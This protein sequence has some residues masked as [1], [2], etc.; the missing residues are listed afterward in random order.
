MTTPLNA[1]EKSTMV[2]VYTQNSLLR[3]EVVTKENVRVS[4]W[5]RTDGA[6]NYMRLLKAQVLFFGGGAPKSYNTSEA[7]VPV[8]SVIGFHLAPPLQEPMDYEEGEKNR[9]V[10]VVSVTVGTFIF[11][12]KIRFSAQSGLG[13]SLEM[14]HTWMSMY[15]TE[16]S[17]PNL[18]QMPAIVVPMLLVNPRQVAITL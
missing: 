8:S 17:N 9:A 15:E 11:K 5:L 16:I 14:A 12:G 1:D 6:P 2:M 4:I 18:P 13:A 3:G 10:Q 7:Y